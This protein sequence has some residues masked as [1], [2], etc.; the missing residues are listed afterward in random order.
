LRTTKREK[1]SPGSRI[2]TLG[3]RVVRVD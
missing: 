1:H 3:F 2:N